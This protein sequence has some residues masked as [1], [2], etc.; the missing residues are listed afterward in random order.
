MAT[1]TSTQSGNFSAT[2]TWGGSGPP[3]VDGDRFVITNGHT[4][5]V[6]SE[7]TAPTNGFGDSNI[8]G[9]LKLGS[10]S[11]LLR[12][13][14]RLYINTNGLLWC[15]DGA[16]IQI[17]GTSGETHG[18]WQENQD[19]ASVIMEGSDGMPYTTLSSNT[20]ENATSFAVAS[21]ENFA[22][23]EWIGVYHF[24]GTQNTTTND[25]YR[26]EGF[27]IHDISGNTI[28][29]RE[30]VGPEDVTVTSYNGSDIV[31]SN[32][33]KFQKSKYIIFGTG[34]NRNIKQISSINYATNT[35]TCNS[36]I[37]GNPI[38]ATVYHTGSE[39]YHSS[40]HKVRK[41]ATINTAEVASSST[42]IT[43]AN[44]NMFTADDE[45]FI[46][47]RSE[48]DGTTDYAHADSDDYH[49]TIS[50][51]SGNTLTLIEQIGYKV[52]AGSIITRL[53]REILIETTTPNTDYGYYYNE[54]YNSN[55]NKKCIIKDV[56]FKNFG[57]DN[58]NVYQ[59]C[60]I[61]G[62]NS[63]NSLPVTL[64]QTVPS[65][66]QGAWVEGV[67]VMNADNHER[68]LGNLLFYSSRY[69][70]G[71]ACV[72]LYGNDGLGASWYDSGNKAY[73]MII[74][75]TEGY[76]GRTEG[77]RERCEFGYHYYSRCTRG[78]RVIGPYEEGNNAFHHIIMDANQYGVESVNNDTVFRRWKMTGLRYGLLSEAAGRPVMIESTAVGLS[79]LTGGIDENNAG[80]YYA[81][82]Y[83]RSTGTNKVVKIIHN[84]FEYD[85]FKMFGYNFTAI[86]DNQENAWL[87]KR[88][89]DN[90][91]SP[92]IEDLVYL[93]PNTTMRVTAKVK[94]VSGFSG[95]YP[96]LGTISTTAAVDDNMVGNAATDSTIFSIARVNPQYT[97]SAA[98]DYEEK[99]VTRGPFDFP[100]YMKAG[101]FSNN[102]DASEGYYIKDFRIYLDPPYA[103]PMFALGNEGFNNPSI[104]STSFK[105]SFT[106]GKIRLGGRIT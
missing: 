10:G 62:Y 59:G 100:C 67:V 77:Y 4:V 60:V 25:T 96:Y 20:N 2:A 37:S 70:K 68:D 16:H 58:N 61:R 56:Y 74:A 50:S 90:D 30:F 106:L 19:G 73:N 23:G 80:G 7:I 52:V 95:T 3:N 55:Y 40:G 103:N 76:A 98:S 8:Y 82:Q 88:R 87:F 78:I 44:A 28:Y 89:R 18:I 15:Q 97:A 54:Y 6:D 93:P 75:G 65:M 86:W 26:D 71:V 14:G 21:A 34:S 33:K 105:D 99:Q 9:V 84:D 29:I 17:T 83:Y 49:H 51:V 46:E 101:V 47:K 57:S 22:V 53:S 94:L 85:S 104:N 32:A 63:T 79:G 35:I 5:T 72:A 38:G 45:I 24:N 92:I 102:R 41:I 12:M 11:S 48:A 69:T 81:N 64:T 43:L 13:D 36:S 91:N 27:W 39:K 66:D 31:V 1:Y 42:T